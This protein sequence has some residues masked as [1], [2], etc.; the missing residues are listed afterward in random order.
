MV[1]QTVREYPHQLGCQTLHYKTLPW[2]SPFIKWMIEAIFIKRCT[3][4]ILVWGHIL[5]YPTKKA[6]VG[7]LNKLASMTIYTP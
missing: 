4:V 3:Y 1:T 6:A 5:R 7:K 2:I